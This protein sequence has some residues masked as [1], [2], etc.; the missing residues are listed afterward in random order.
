MPVP[1]FIV[2]CYDPNIVKYQKLT[3]TYLMAS[4]MSRPILTQFF[5]CLGRDTGNPDTQ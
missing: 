2:K 5:A 3:E 4:H 1:S